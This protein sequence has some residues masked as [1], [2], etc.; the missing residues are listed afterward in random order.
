M[1]SGLTGVSR[2]TRRRHA[3]D[4]TRLGGGNVFTWPFVSCSA[5]FISVHILRSSAVLTPQPI[6]GAGQGTDGW[7]V[8]TRYAQN[9]CRQTG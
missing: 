9:A 7:Y 3:G 1:Q 8:S 5:S 6:A 2:Q 4:T